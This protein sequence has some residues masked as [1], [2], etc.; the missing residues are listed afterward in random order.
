VIQ[1]RQNI[2]GANTASADTNASGSTDATNFSQ[3]IGQ[4]I[5]LELSKFRARNQ[6]PFFVKYSQTS[7]G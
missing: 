4:E 2:K 3:L 6:A 5:E 7:M 1:D